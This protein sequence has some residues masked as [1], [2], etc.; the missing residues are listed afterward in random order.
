MF[1]FL[2]RAST[3]HRQMCIGQTVYFP[4]PFCSPALSVTSFRGLQHRFYSR[5][6][7]F[8]SHQQQQ[9]TVYKVN[10]VTKHSLI[11]NTAVF[12][13]NRLYLKHKHV[14]S[15]SPTPWRNVRTEWC[16]ISCS[17]LFNVRFHY[18]G[19]NIHPARLYLY[20]SWHEH[21]SCQIMACEYGYIVPT[22]FVHLHFETLIPYWH[23]VNQHVN[24]GRDH[25]RGTPSR[26]YCKHEYATVCRH[27]CEMLARERRT[28]SLEGWIVCY[29]ASLSHMHGLFSVKM[30]LSTKKNKCIASEI[31][32]FPW[33][34]YLKLFVIY[35]CT[36]IPYMTV[37][38]IKCHTD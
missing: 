19:I 29:L 1:P 30:Y 33:K 6:R 20:D 7:P 4:A 26:C 36:W 10:T 32:S 8:Q 34:M 11:Q 18:G 38:C 12:G 35:Q 3:Y 27:A 25:D 37:S 31:C 16:C 22:W 21:F 24:D 28:S 13:E 14:F 17:K 23:Y 15:Y 2:S 5:N 9:K